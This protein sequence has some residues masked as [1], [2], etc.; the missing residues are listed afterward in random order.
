MPPPPLKEEPVPEPAP[1]RSEIVDAFA[2]SVSRSSAA[3]AA[4]VITELC[5]VLLGDKSDSRKQ[6]NGL[7]NLIIAGEQ[8]TPRCPRGQWLTTGGPRPDGDPCSSRCV[9]AHAA[10]DLADTWFREQEALAETA[11]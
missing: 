10:L 8:H 9:A 7:M 1:K 5:R 2:A 4:I 6:D 3:S 11:G